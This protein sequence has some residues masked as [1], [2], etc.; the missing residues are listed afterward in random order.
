[1]A[2][3]NSGMPLMLKKQWMRNQRVFLYVGLITYNKRGCIQYYFEEI[4][5][6][7]QI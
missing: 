3:L 5:Y 7:Y 1:M 2:T 6:T 4:A